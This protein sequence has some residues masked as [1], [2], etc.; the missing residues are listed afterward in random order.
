MTLTQIGNTLVLPDF[1]DSDFDQLV[2]AKI[3]RQ[4]DLERSVLGADV[5]AWL[6]WMLL[7]GY[8]PKANQH[9]VFADGGVNAIRLTQNTLCAALDPYYNALFASGDPTHFA[10]VE[11][12]TRPLPRT[13]LADKA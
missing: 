8:R 6:H 11:R 9:A 7:G 5:T 13:A 1:A 2:L 3:G 12:A 10:L 4:V